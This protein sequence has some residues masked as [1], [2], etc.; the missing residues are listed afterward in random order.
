MKINV[1]IE[2]TAQ[3]MRDFL[4]LPNV[5]PL[6]DEM[7]QVIRDNM[8]KGVAGFDA[9][10]LM[11]PLLPVQ[12]PALEAL[13]KAFWDAFVQAGKPGGSSANPPTYEATP[14]AGDQ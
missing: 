11:K 6:Q 5:Q 8:Q 12:L 13:Q 7:M 9:L 14:G 4:G 2:A 1:S 10:S 3:E